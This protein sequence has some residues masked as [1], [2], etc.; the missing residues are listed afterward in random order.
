MTR[1]LGAPAP[2]EGDRAR[3]PLHADVFEKLP[4]GL[5]VWRLDDPEEPE[6]LQLVNSN[7]AA[8]RMLGQPDALG[9]RVTARLVDVIRSGIERD[10]GEVAC[11]ER[12]LSVKA[13]PLPERCVGV[14]LEDLT[15]SRQAQEHM[16]QSQRMETLGR[17]AAGIAHDFN[18]I[19]AVI[20][21][22]GELALHLSKTHELRT[23]LHGLLDAARKA[24]ALNQQ[25]LA[26]SRRQ[27]LTPRIVDLRVVISGVWRMLSRLVGEGVSLVTDLP[28]ELGRVRLDP[29]QIEQVAVNL[30]VN[31]RDAMSG[32]GALT[33]RLSDVVRTRGDVASDEGASAG[34]HVL[35]EVTDTGAGMTH[36]TLERAFEPFFTT[37]APAHGTGLGLVT[38][39]RIVRQSGGHIEVDSVPGHGTTFRI[40]LPRVQDPPEPQGA[41]SLP[42]GT[43][44]ILVVEAEAPPRSLL[45]QG[46]E[47]LGYS[48]LEA[49]HPKQ[50][51]HFA[52]DDS[53]DVQ[54]LLSGVEMP[55]MTGPE[56][57]ACLTSRW[58]E[59]KVVFVSGYPDEVTADMLMGGMH[60]LQKPFASAELAHTVREALDGPER[61]P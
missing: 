12:V 5:V 8:T 20:V 38:V 27:A 61:L 4:V 45:R 13:F 46:L 24:A 6:R 7:P 44:T 22:Y 30:A 1:T 43:E 49:E 33:F 18:N 3:G 16:C 23:N 52:E 29:G 9:G 39:D 48:V 57:W 53:A 17:L 34:P 25:L 11:A 21:G 19:V 14:V 15:P 35:L 54:L 42:R 31:A 47:A 2:V 37:K 41:A 50:A 10:L 26:F 59:L 32:R 40:Y 58:R 28:P 36:E 55:Q 60:V 51:L 56:L